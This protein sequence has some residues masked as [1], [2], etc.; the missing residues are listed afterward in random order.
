MINLK[1]LRIWSR[2]GF[3]EHCYLT[4]EGS[5]IAAIGPMSDCPA[6]GESL[7]CQGYTAY[8]GFIDGHSHL[9]M[10][11]D[12]IGAEGDDGNES[13][14]P[15]TP[16]LRGIDSVYAMD[17]GFADALAA[18][19]TTVV[20]GPGSA[21]AIAGT[22]CAI[23]T[24]GRIVD[25]MVIQSPVAMKMA[26][27]ENPKGIYGD[28]SDTP[29]TRMAT[30]ALVREQL[31]KAQRYLQA[32]EKA[33]EDPDADEPEFDMKC[34]ALLPVLRRELPV[35]IHAH[36]ADDIATAVRICH[37]FDLRYVLVHATEGH[38]IADYLAKENISV[39][40][41]PMINHRSKPELAGFVMDSPTQLAQAGIPISICTDHP[42]IPQDLLAVSAGLCVREGLPWQK[43]MEAITW[44]PAVQAGIENR[45]GSLAP[46]LDADLVLFDT[47]PLTLEAR[48]ALVMINGQIVHKKFTK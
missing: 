21:N 13:T 39:I 42:E 1:N 22:F 35:H 24:Y 36:R 29:S 43:A 41:G 44:V 26:F 3:S 28:K 2:E 30:A 45:V 46:G 14:D 4:V 34:E 8:P 27:G 16:Q 32:L 7:D 23:K 15:I 12:S 20:T 48:P 25:E 10:F 40:C 37:E 18:G 31:F 6:E 17:R 38:L 19:V 11:D 33:A 9:G 5:H 47:D